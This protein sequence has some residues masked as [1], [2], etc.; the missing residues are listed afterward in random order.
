MKPEDAPRALRDR[1][2]KAREAVE[3]PD[4]T[5]LLRAAREVASTV[6]EQA[7]RAKDQ[8][9]VRVV[10]KRD[11]VR[12]TVVGPRAVRYRRMV[13]QGLEARMDAAKAEIRA[14]ITRRAR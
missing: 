3:S 1:A 4:V 11:G 12:I 10:E 2:Q 13:Q 6:R 5:P 9:S 8:I 14:Q 7:H